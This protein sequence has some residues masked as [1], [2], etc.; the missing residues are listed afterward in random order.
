[1]IVDKIFDEI[2]AELARFHTK[3]RLGGFFIGLIVISKS[4]LALAILETWTGSASDFGSSFV[5]KLF[6]IKLYEFVGLLV[7]AFLV[8]PLL[9]KLM[10]TSIVRFD[11]S[12]ASKYFFEVYERIDNKDMDELYR[13]F[14]GIRDDAKEGESKILYLKGL[15]ELLVFLII[16][17]GWVW[18]SGEIIRPLYVA[19]FIASL[20]LLVLLSQKILATYLALI[21][22]YKV[23]EVKI[24]KSIPESKV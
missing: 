24:K 10:V 15:S 6:E 14:K 3:W 8:A 16:I 11:F 13:E 9:N 12:S 17:G 2:T 18:F 22:P 21:Y 23:A 5:S 20:A 4:Y 7:V 1:M 19:V